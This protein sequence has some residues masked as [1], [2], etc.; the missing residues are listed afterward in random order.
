ML[1]NWVN[2]Q[3]SIMKIFWDLAQENLVNKQGSY[4][5]SDQYL[6]MSAIHT[7]DMAIYE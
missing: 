4:G 1:N 5:I 3:F 2:V 6:W 7:L